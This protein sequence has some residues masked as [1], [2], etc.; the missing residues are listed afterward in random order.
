MLLI[1]LKFLGLLSD[2]AKATR[3][4]DRWKLD[5]NDALVV[6]C[7]VNNNIKTLISLDKDFDKVAN[8]KRM[9]L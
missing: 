2:M 7:M 6:A 3:C 5:F 4:I 8:L 1:T 9:K